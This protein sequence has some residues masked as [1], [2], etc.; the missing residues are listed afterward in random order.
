MTSLSCEYP[1][2][3]EA[4]FRALPFAMRIMNT[5]HRGNP[6]SF[7]PVPS[8]LIENNAKTKSPTSLRDY[9][10]LPNATKPVWFQDWPAWSFIVSQLLNKDIRNT[11]GHGSAKH[12]VLTGRVL[13]DRIDTSGSGHTFVCGRRSRLALLGLPHS[14]GPGR[15]EAERQALRPAGFQQPYWLGDALKLHLA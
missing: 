7:G 1:Q 3:Y 12:E 4:C 13:A 9:A 15:D 14:A 11:I 2:V 5:Q 6:N 8:L 10:A